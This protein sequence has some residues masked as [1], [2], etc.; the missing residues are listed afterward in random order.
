MPIKL[1]KVN[2]SENWYARGTHCGVRVYESTGLSDKTLAEAY[3]VN[4][5]GKI[6]QSHA[7]G[8]KAAVIF[9]TAM[10]MHV[11]AGGSPRY[12]DAILK[13]VGMRDVDTLRQSDLDKLAVDLYPHASNSTRNRQVYSPFIAVMNYAANSDFCPYRKWRRPKAGE[14]GRKTRFATYEE[15]AKFHA[16]AA[17]HIQPLIVLLAYGGLRMGE[18]INLQ[19]EDI[20]LDRRWMIIRKTKTGKPRGVPMHACLVRELKDV[21]D[22]TGNVILSRGTRAYKRNYSGGNVARKSRDGAALRAGIE[23]LTWHDLRHTCATWLQMAA[24]D[25]ETRQDILGH[26]RGRDVHDIYI[27]VPEARMIAAIDS[28]KDFTDFSHTS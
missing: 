15:I 21:K 3:R 1:V 20:D 4:L 22:K 8:R 19:W 7:Y 26:S 9:A 24:V 12:L 6:Q 25:R 27:H 14:K 28:L 11:E 13:A 17:K 16:A 10:R 2:G 23:H 5:E 18:A